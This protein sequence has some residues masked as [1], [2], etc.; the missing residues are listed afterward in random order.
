MKQFHEG[1]NISNY[2]II[3]TLGQGG[4]GTVYEVEHAPM[5]SMCPYV[6]KRKSQIL[7]YTLNAK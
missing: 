2:R 7:F 6:F 4:M 1:D 5:R 3:R